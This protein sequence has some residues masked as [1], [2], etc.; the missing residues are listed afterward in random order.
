MF[1]ALKAELS[2][3]SDNFYEDYMKIKLFL[4]AIQY[5]AAT[6]DAKLFEDMYF[7]QFED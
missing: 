4:W 6:G 5:V 1:D 7:P 2:E 3:R